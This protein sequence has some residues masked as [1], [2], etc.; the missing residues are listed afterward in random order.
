MIKTSKEIGDS[1]AICAF[2]GMLRVIDRD[3]RVAF[4]ADTAA[5]SEVIVP[6][7]RRSCLRSSRT[8]LSLLFFA[9]FYLPRT[10]NNEGCFAED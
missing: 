1:N 7:S 6:V 3:P 8:S 9:F 2:L 4:A 10:P 5:T